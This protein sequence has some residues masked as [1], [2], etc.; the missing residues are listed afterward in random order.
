MRIFSGFPAGKPR[1]TLMPSGFFTDAL[2]LID[3]VNELKVVLYAF[4]AI[5]QR[6]GDFRYLTRADLAGDA[7]FMRGIGSEAALDEALARACQRGLLLRADVPLNG[8]SVTLYFINAEPGRT[9]IEQ[10]RRGAWQPSADAAGAVEILP[11]RPNVFTLYE[12]NIGALT[13]IIAEHLKDAERDYPAGWVQDAIRAAVEANARSWNYI[14][15]VLERWKKEGRSHE[16]DPAGAGR[17]WR[18]YVSDD[19]APYI[20]NAND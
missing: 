12:Q 6:E 19:Y 5:Q 16:N 20:T 11:E 3:D 10:I 1:V 9:A 15:A 8:Q 18:D 2:P 14:R 4:Y 7:A 17:H 13:A